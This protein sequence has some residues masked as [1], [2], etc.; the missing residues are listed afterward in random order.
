MA[1]GGTSDN[2]DPASIWYSEEAH[3]FVRK[4][5]QINYFGREGWGIVNY[6]SKDFGR[7]RLHSH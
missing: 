7:K 2:A 1:S 6:E 3:N 4:L 5:D